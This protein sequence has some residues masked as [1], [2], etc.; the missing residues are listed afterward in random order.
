LRTQTTSS[1]YYIIFLR[2]RQADDSGRLVQ[3]GDLKVFDQ[4]PKNPIQNREE[5]FA[6]RDWLTT[7]LLQAK[8]I[9]AGK[10][11]DLAK[12]KALQ[13]HYF[14][15]GVEGTEDLDVEEEEEKPASKTP[16]STSFFFQAAM[17]YKERQTKLQPVPFAEKP[18][19]T[20]P[21]YPDNSLAWYPKLTNGLF[22]VFMHND[23]ELKP[24]A[25]QPDDDWT[26]NWKREIID[27]ITATSK[28]YNIEPPPPYQSL[29]NELAFFEKHGFSSKECRQT[30]RFFDDQEYHE[31]NPQEA[32]HEVE[33]LKTSFDW[34]PYQQAFWWGE[35]QAVLTSDIQTLPTPETK[36][37]DELP[38]LEI[39]VAEGESIHLEYKP[40][41]LYNFKTKKIGYEPK[42][43]VAKTIAGFL[44]AKGGYLLI[45]YSDKGESIGLRY[46]FS[47]RS[48]GKDP[49]DYFRLEFDKLLNDYFPKPA[50]PFIEGRMTKVKGEKAKDTFV[51]VVKVKPSTFPVF[52]LKTEKDANENTWFTTKKFVYRKTASTQEITDIE[53]IATYCRH[54]WPV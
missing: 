31:G 4:H 54:K 36:V 7:N 49:F 2:Y 32:F 40:A 27:R 6:Y 30:I 1:S 17:K 12:G 15:P 43:N 14:D 39:A 23:P 5:A 11:S 53:D 50:H 34:T 22:V 10:L 38:S 16:K 45:G 3:Y 46:D 42:W 18:H 24:Y 44:N 8:G 51:F 48:H 21:G 35:P 26:P 28:H 37:S 9:E 13:L 29:V 33:I 52:V 20:K 41:M 47:L 25:P 19:R